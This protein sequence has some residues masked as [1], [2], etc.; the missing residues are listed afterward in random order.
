MKNA[1]NQTGP[2]YWTNEKGEFHRLDGPAL[3]YDGNTEWWVNGKTHRENGPAM[4]WENGTTQ[5]RINGQL[6]REDGPAVTTHDCQYWCINGKN[7]R[8]DGPAVIEEDG[9]VNWWTNGKNITKEVEQWLS[10]NN[11]SYPFNDEEKVLF[12]LRFV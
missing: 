1:P 4:I 11:I 12:K 10:A 3:I 6:H 9:T 8:E 2:K 7:H 5:W